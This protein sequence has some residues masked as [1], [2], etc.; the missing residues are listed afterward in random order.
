MTQ[1]RTATAIAQDVNLLVGLGW[2]RDMTPPEEKDLFYQKNGKTAIVFVTS[3]PEFTDK[4]I[5]KRCDFDID[6][7]P[8]KKEVISLLPF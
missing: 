2:K 5:F 1:E 4:A 6:G 7:N 3:S 8:V